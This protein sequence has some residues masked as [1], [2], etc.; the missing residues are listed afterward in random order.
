MLAYILGQG[1][2][3]VTRNNASTERMMGA[4][5]LQS[6]MLDARVDQVDALY[7]GNMTGGALSGQRQLGVAIASDLG[8]DGIEV[9]RVEVA[10]A[11][12]AGALRAGILAIASGLHE[13][14]AVVGVERMTHVDFAAITAA[15][16]TGA[17]AQNE[18]GSSF[19][20]L[21][22]LLM[23]EYLRRYR[24]DRNAL[25]PFAQLAHTNALQNPNAVFGRVVTADDYTNSR[26]V[27]DPVRVLD[28]SPLC[29][30]AAALILSRRAPADVGVP[31][32]AIVA[33]AVTTDHLA[34]T[35]RPDI[36]ALRAAG[37]SLSRALEQAALSRDDLSFFEAHD[38]YTIMA[39]VTLESCGFVAQGQA[40]HA[41]AAGEFSVGGRLPISTM[42][43]LKGRG[44]PV[45]ATGVYQVAE[46]F[47]QVT[48]RAGTC[49]I[50]GARYGAAQNLGGAAAT[51]ITHIVA[52]SSP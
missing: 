30:G 52:R 51:V 8:L 28:A 36:L 11:S 25:A 40:T 16:A 5:A 44:H 17:D 2:V 37:T 42:G 27:A 29:D 10:S 13:R 48:G 23:Q 22:A 6:A 9:L 15:L 1:Q 49:Q 41:A 45:G 26:V 43:G 39:A 19:L 14:V 7:V 24:L 46:C 34:I 35:Q 32:A 20:S 18:S 12:G 47:Q 4:R 33:S 3:A 31:H 50:E 38:A 21:N